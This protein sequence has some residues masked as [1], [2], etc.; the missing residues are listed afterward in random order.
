MKS[1]V[2]IG[3]IIFLLGGCSTHMPVP[4]AA[5][6]LKTAEPA[7][8]MPAAKV[9]E[10]PYCCTLPQELDVTLPQLGPIVNDL[11]R[12][13]QSIVPYA[14]Q[15]GMDRESFYDVQ[16]NFEKSYY[17][18]WDY[19]VPPM[20]V[21]DVSWPMRAFRGGYGSN[22]R[23]LPPSWFKE[24]EAHA[25]FENYG[26]LNQKGIALKWLDLR[27]LP[28]EKPLYRDPS[29]PGEG[30]PFD[31]LQNSS[32]NYHE[33]VFISHT[34]IDG[35]WSYVFTNSASGW[36]KSDGI[37]VIDTAMSETMRKQ[38]KLFIT[39]DN[40][41]LYDSSNRFV[42]Y[43][44]I[45]MVLSLEKEQQNEYYAL[46]YDSNGSFKS[47][48]IP[49]PAARV[50]ISKLNKNDLIRLGEQMLKNTYGWGGMLGERDCSS[51]IRDMYTPF[52]IWLPRNS[53]AQARK[54]EVISFE[55]L[56]DDEKL[57][58]IREK[59]I[60]FETIVYLKGHVLLYIGTYQDNVMMMHNVWGIR[61]I[62]KSG[63][64][65][66]RIVGKAV[67][68]TL[69]FGSELEEFDPY[70]KLLTRAHSM[71]IFTKTPIVL[72]KGAGKPV[73]KKKAL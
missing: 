30:Y 46:A 55:G 27:A 9:G 22:L 71:N 28:T 1:T 73:K 6:S 11:E 67:I 15:N 31:M 16:K 59:G 7:T 45:G 44:R 43:S 24:I 4:K 42:A 5:H 10:S 35:A 34:S 49:K 39:E 21:Q 61:T 53:A 65:G 52:G 37:A 29:L 20:S 68:S 23:P 33:P 54:G 38:E 3:G 64:K 51:M 48:S 14:E 69:E 41:P 2:W 19:T 60:P 72:S 17:T 25:N 56:S 8:M 36:V 12:F 13:E 47:V 50:G 57:D 58:L 26:T 63:N 32:V 66:R 70:N 18:P 40:V 62:D